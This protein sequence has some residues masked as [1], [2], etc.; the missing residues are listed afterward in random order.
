MADL[1]R[2]ASLRFR[3][4]TRVRLETWVLDNSAAATVYRGQPM[5]ID[6]SEDTV[7]IRPWVDAVT[8]VSAADIFVGIALAGATV[9]TTDTETDNKITVAGP[10]SE[11]GF[12]SAVFTDADV[13]DF[14]GFTD[15]A[16]LIATVIAG[17]ADIIPIG[18]LVR[19]ENGYAYVLLNDYP[20]LM[21]F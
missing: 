16:T 12:K 11:V 2:D 4:D 9:L 17:T 3:G 20:I 6:A 21:A 19:V 14:V 10:G 15:S 5:F 7:Y 13:G 8:L 18:R 1:T